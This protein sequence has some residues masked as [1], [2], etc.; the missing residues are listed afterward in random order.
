MPVTD[1]IKAAVEKMQEGEKIGASIHFSQPVTKLL[2]V[3]VI[4]T[5][6]SI[7]RKT[8]PEIATVLEKRDK[9]IAKAR[10]NATLHPEVVKQQVKDIERRVNEELDTL[11]AKLDENVPLLRGQL[12]HYSHA[13]CLQRAQHADAAACTAVSMR[14]ARLSS[15]GLV[16]AARMAVATSD[17]ATIGCISDEVSARVDL[18]TSDPRGVS[19]EARAEINALVAQVPSDSAKV[20]ALLAEYD[21]R[22]RRA[23]I[24]S[25][26]ATRST[27]KIAAGL[28]A[29]EQ[30][31]TK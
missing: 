5:N 16:E 20:T 4:E 18:P 12:E 7:A 24:A 19:R 13:R 11:L 6:V 29:R 3:G 27:D 30:G 28:L 8:E 9:A 23:L 25:G 31:V 1:R 21:L 17:A 2:D 14:L 22:R 15:A 10:S 26:R